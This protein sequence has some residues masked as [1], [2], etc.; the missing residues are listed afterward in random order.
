MNGGRADGLAVK[1]CPNCH[2]RNADAAT[3]CDQ[4]GLPLSSAAPGAAEPRTGSPRAE[5]TRSVPPPSVPPPN[6]KPLY[7]IG[8]PSAARGSHSGARIPRSPF[9]Y[10]AL[11]H[12]RGRALATAGAAVGLAL[13]LA[14][15]GLPGE[16]DQGGTLTP[17]AKAAANLRSQQSVRVHFRAT[18][19]DPASGRQLTMTGHGV[20]A[21]SNGNGRASFRFSSR[22]AAANSS[23]DAAALNGGRMIEIY[24]HPS[25]YIGGSLFAGQL[26]D[27]ASWMKIDLQRASEANG[28]NLQAV[29]EAQQGNAASVLPY[30]RAAEADVQNLG[31]ERI[32]GVPTTHLR[33][34][35]DLR[36]YADAL[37]SEGKTEAADSIEN[38]LKLGSEISPIDVW[39]DRRQLVRRMGFTLSLPRP[40]GGTAQMTMVMD[41]SDFGVRVA[42]AP[43]PASQVFDATSLTH[44]GATGGAGYYPPAS[45]HA[46]AM[47][48]DWRAFAE[49][50]DYACAS[51]FNATD[52]ARVKADRKAARQGVPG[53]KRNS[54]GWTY[55]ASAQGQLH[56]A[57]EAMG[58]PPARAS[59]FRRW[60]ENVGE[61]AR[62]M[63]RMSAAWADQNGALESQTYSRIMSLKAQAN[64]LGQRFGLRI[65]TSNGP[66]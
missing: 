15:I 49:R 21:L 62:L 18:I 29:Q 39:L 41:F 40:D 27:N 61:R 6:A 20:S 32:S 64:R 33:A 44:R 9:S 13:I 28:I 37:R 23:P 17:L 4:C 26:P 16:D 7:R 45:S 25:I 30:L 24:D 60:V 34:E 14:V 11:D 55:M 46:G 52:A 1:A 43:P 36:H 56:R 51:I 48:P 54:M 38:T 22:G 63:Q 2:G 31:T 3:A 42:A 12:W 19:E 66:R 47:T 10:A 65:C 59:L 53:Y 5:A 58:D 8:S 50:V 57:V 35:I